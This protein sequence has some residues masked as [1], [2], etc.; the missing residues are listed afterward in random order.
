MV[1]WALPEQRLFEPFFE[2]VELVVRT[3]CWRWLSTHMETITFWS[4]AICYLRFLFSVAII[5]CWASTPPFS[6][7]VDYWVWGTV[8]PPEKQFLASEV[9]LRRRLNEEVLAFF[10]LGLALLSWL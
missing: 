3:D 7:P 10:T 9:L 1:V 8:Q 6:K 4:W 5:S 2:V